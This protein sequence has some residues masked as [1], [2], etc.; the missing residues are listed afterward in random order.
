MP[1]KKLGFKNRGLNFLVLDVPA[2]MF[3]G[4]TEMAGLMLA[5]AS[6]IAFGCRKLA[7]SE[8][9]DGNARYRSISLLLVS[10][11]IL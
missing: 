5:L 6:M 8:L 10:C 2:C 7:R 1:V 11:N 4:E 9:L 3:S